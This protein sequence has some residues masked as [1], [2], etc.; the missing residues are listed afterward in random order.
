[1]HKR[2]SEAISV[3]ASLVIALALMAI[4]AAPRAAAQSGESQP[5]PLPIPPEESPSGDWLTFTK[6]DGLGENNLRAIWGDADGTV[7]FGTWG[8]GVT[9]FDGATWRTF[10]EQDGLA[11]NWILSL[12]GDALGNVWM[13]GVG[14]DLEGFDVQIEG[15]GFSRF[16]ADSGQWRTFA[17]EDG[18]PQALVRVLWP[19][20]Q[21]GVWLGTA[22]F[23]GMDL[24]LGSECPEVIYEGKGLTHFDPLNGQWTTYTTADGLVNDGVRALWVDGSGLLWVGTDGGVS[25]LNPASGEWTSYTAADG[26]AGDRVQALWGDG[27]GTVWAGLEPVWDEASRQANGGGLS[28][29]DAATEQWTSYAVADGLGGNDVT[30]IW[31]YELNGMGRV[32]AATQN[33]AGGTCQYMGLSHWDGRQW[34]Q[35]TAEDGLPQNWVGAVWG[36]E[37][38]TLWVGTQMGA[39]RFDG[40]HWTKTF[41]PQGALASDDVTA[42]YGDNQGYIWAGTPSGLSRLNT[43]NGEWSSYTTAHGL[44]SNAIDKLWIDSQG[45]LWVGTAEGLGRLDPRTD[46]W[47]V[48]TIDDGLI[49]NGVRAIWAGQDGT[50]WVATTGA[51]SRLDEQ[52]NRWESYTPGDLTGQVLIMEARPD[53]EGTVWLGTFPTGLVGFRPETG[54]IRSY[55]PDELQTMLTTAV[56]VDAQGYVWLGTLDGI[57]VFDPR[58]EQWLGSLPDSAYSFWLDDAGHMWSGTS[59]AAMV[60]DPEAGTWTPFLEWDGEGSISPWVMQS[61][62]IGRSGEVWLGTEAGLRAYDPGTGEWTVHTAGGQSGHLLTTDLRLEPG[63]E[64]WV[65][66][67][68]GGLKHWNGRS[69][70]WMTFDKLDLVQSDVQALHRDAAGMLWAIDG[71][72]VGRY[73]ET[74]S[75]WVHYGPDDGFPSVY[76]LDLAVDRDGIVWAGTSTDGLVRYDPAT[77]EGNL[78]A[79]AEEVGGNW[80][81]AIDIDSRG[82]IWAGFRTEHG[83]LRFDPVSEAWTPYPLAEGMPGL[84]LFAHAQVWSVHVDHLDWVWVG[85]SEGLAGYDQASDTWVAHT[86]ADGMAPGYVQ[87]VWTDS[88]GT[89]WVGTDTGGL[90]RLDIAAYLPGERP[91][92]WRQWRVFTP[93]NSGL[94]SANVVALHG[95]PDSPYGDL[96]IGSDAWYGRYRPQPPRLGVTASTSDGTTF[97]C[98]TLHE[99]DPGA[100]V[101]GL[102][103]QDFSHLADEIAYRWRLEG[104][105]AT[106]S[107]SAESGAWRFVPNTRDEK[108]AQVTISGVE[109]GEHAF[110]VAAGNLDLDWSAPVV[111]R[112]MVRDVSPPAVDL[113]ASVQLDF[114]GKNAASDN[115]SAVSPPAQ[116]WQ[117]ARRF[118]WRVPFT[119]NLTPPQHLTYHYNL[120]GA[121][122]VETGQYRP[123]QPPSVE[124]PPGRYLLN[125]SAEDEAGTESASFT[126]TVTVPQPLAIQYLPYA[127][128]GV[129]GLALVAVAGRWYWRRRSKFRYLD[130]ALQASRAR[131]RSGHRITLVTKGW[132]GP[133]HNLVDPT[134][135]LPQGVLEQLASTKGPSGPDSDAALETLGT[136]LYRA[137]LGPEMRQHLAEQTRRHHLRLRLSFAEGE[138]TLDELPWE[139]LHGGDGLGFLGTN[140]RTALARFQQPPEARG[141]PRL[142]TRLPLRILVMVADAPNLPSLDIDRERTMLASLSDAPGRRFRVD[143][144]SEATLARL[145]AGLE[146]GYDVVHFIGHGDVDEEGAFVYMLDPRGNEALVTPSD[147]ARAIR[148]AAVLPKLVLFNACNTAAAGGNELGMAPVLMR[149]ANLSAVIGMQYP[150]SD[151]AAARFTEGFY[152]ALIHHGQ[153]DYA[154]AQGRKA[155]A[156]SENTTPRDWACPVLYAQVADGIIFDRV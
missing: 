64:L 12:A 131:D 91:R 27:M 111:C 132:D 152:N 62:W 115:P 113:G 120:A 53:G 114:D 14:I 98:D 143:F 34:L 104:P 101:F 61:I 106:G 43:M 8:G 6:A 63:G 118:T 89:I 116:F 126:S 57:F 33:V 41:T 117:G 86:G 3:V 88:R 112:F 135:F 75:Q 119:D 54:E 128:L 68:D 15:R 60:W 26:L 46:R 149:D 18:L 31:A 154:V 48:Y 87:S 21:G 20:Q 83:L 150:V 94:A 81:D 28:R 1:M 51:I 140:P 71:L 66:T 22:E 136:A 24:T 13:A 139:F 35:V 58:Q 133:Q 151:E 39:S 10:T 127:G 80:I 82:F 122:I 85:T 32:W 76:P 130:V 144:E 156:A 124:L 25:R 108:R 103:A 37:R 23:K 100:V 72:G 30:E 77:G 67:E 44:P 55:F 138:S 42:L 78:Y 110:T 74:D 59:V 95:V 102:V 56:A 73:D 4:Q 84:D 107:Q 36:D 134:A 96:L 5:A 147:L 146:K 2:T 125:V 93:G 50:T 99:V 70:E 38:G 47:Q 65:G 141:G 153:V 19:D 17:T 105:S 92:A 9:S 7:W 142:K 40:S 79:Y 49:D 129:L 148:G 155:I 69:G 123:D 52:S 97:S 109:P 29:F 16:D 145:Q 45:H 90:S 121:G 11:S 137:L